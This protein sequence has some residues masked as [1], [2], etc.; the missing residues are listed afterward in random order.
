[1]KNQ[2]KIKGKTY[3]NSTLLNVYAMRG[4]WNAQQAFVLTKRFLKDR[5]DLVKLPD[6]VNGG[7]TYWIPSS[8]WVQAQDDYKE[9]LWMQL[10][11]IDGKGCHDDPAMMHVTESAD[12]ADSIA[13]DKKKPAEDV[14]KLIRG[15][16]DLLVAAG[17][18]QAV[19][20]E[21]AGQNKYNDQNVFLGPDAAEKITMLCLQLEDDD[22]PLKNTKR[23][24]FE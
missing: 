21:D 8:E 5:K 11:P 14:Y 7:V 9:Y 17:I 16:S 4:L 23:F 18:P 22:S 15:V 6:P 12:L 1:M 13:R 24:Q 2:I 19:T 3:I 20:S 10:D